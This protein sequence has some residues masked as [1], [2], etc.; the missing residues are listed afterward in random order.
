MCRAGMVLLRQS[1]KFRSAGEA[2]DPSL[3][4]A[5]GISL[6]PAF[7]GTRKAYVVVDAPSGLRRHCNRAMAPRLSRLFIHVPDVLE[8]LPLAALLLPHHGIF[9]GALLRRLGFCLDA[10]AA[11]LARRAAAERLH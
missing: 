9:E 11:D 6:V 10:A 8:Q 7:A 4:R 5:S 3:S 2:G 1:R